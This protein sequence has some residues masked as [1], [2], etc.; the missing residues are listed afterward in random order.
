MP[1]DW[2]VT[3]G[4]A[5]GDETVEVEAG[6]EEAAV[7]PE[8]TAAEVVE[9]VVAGLVA[10]TVELTL[11]DDEVLEQ[12]ITLREQITS[13]TRTSRKLFITGTSKC[14]NIKQSHYWFAILTH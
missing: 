11:V 2:G 12:P 8:E 14:I 7:V 3:E 5:A 6:L 13:K 1:P 9:L 10:E 4:E